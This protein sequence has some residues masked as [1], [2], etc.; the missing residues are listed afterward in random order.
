MM[1]IM[2]IMIILKGFCFITYIDKAHAKQAAEMVS[3]WVAMDLY[4]GIE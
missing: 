3:V 4:V 1:I 2:N